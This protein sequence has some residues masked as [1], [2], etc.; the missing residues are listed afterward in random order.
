MASVVRMPAQAVAS[1]LLPHLGPG[2]VR[3][4]AQFGP[5]ELV[6]GPNLFGQHPLGL[7][8]EIEYLPP[9]AGELPGLALP[10]LLPGLVAFKDP[11]LL[12][13]GAAPFQQGIDQPQQQPP[14]AVD[15]YPQPHQ[16][17]D[18]EGGGSDQGS[19]GTSADGE[20]RVVCP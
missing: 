6:E 7:A 8:I 11:I 10:L 15:Q 19:Q 12:H 20:D 16:Q 13:A 2:T 18:G 3:R 14:A 5:A 17:G 1:P 4:Q 9:L